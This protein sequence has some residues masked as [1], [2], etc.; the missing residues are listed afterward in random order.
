MSSA[1]LTAT[2]A[3]YEAFPFVAGGAKRIRHWSGRL[4]ESLPDEL[5]RGRT[6]LDLGCGSGEATR[7]L[8]DRGAH[9]VSVDLTMAAAASTRDLNRDAAVCQANALELP[10]GDS[11][12]FHSVAIG[13]LHHTPDTRSGLQEMARVTEAGGRIV[14]LLYS[15]WTPY[16]LLYTS[17][18]PLRARIPV[19]RLDRAPRWMLS[20]MRIVVAAQIGQFLADAQLKRLLADQFWTPRAS[21]HS[22]RK[23]TS[24]A[25]ELGLAVA[26]RRRL[27]FHA[28]L[29]ALERKPEGLK[30]WQRGGDRETLSS[31]GHVGR[32][33]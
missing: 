6:V 3:H 25:H 11:S 28:N 14:I 26:W 32:D 9:M 21:F 27:I 19:Q 33:A 4:R 10:F 18:A 24:W 7:G 22:W 13:V 1:D 12:F 31:R 29:V 30:P 16:H 17:S 20:V 15:R 8:A 2:K 23:I 5:L